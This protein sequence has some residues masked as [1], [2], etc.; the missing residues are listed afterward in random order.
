MSDSLDLDLTE[1][2]LDRLQAEEWEILLDRDAHQVQQD[3]TPL[4]DGPS[5]PT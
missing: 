4:Y 5:G 1:G 2:Q 3:A